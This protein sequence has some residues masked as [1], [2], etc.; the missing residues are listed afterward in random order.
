MTL[1]TQDYGPFADIVK[2]A[3]SIMAMG[4]AIGLGWRGR[5]K[6]EPIEEDVP[7]GPRK[8]GGLIAAITVALIWVGLNDL[9]YLPVLTKIALYCLGVAFLSLM[10]YI[11]LQM[12][13]YEVVRVPAGAL[14]GTDVTEVVKVIGGLWLRSDARKKLGKEDGPN[15]VQDLFAGSAYKKDAL[16][17]RPAQGLAKVFFALAYISLTVAGTV[18]LGAAS[19]LIALKMRAQ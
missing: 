12:L 16:W 8:V 7:A 14:P 10:I 19:I 6:W 3:G 15:T 2:I 18:A 11:L 1:T 4:L 9:Q 13:V 17:P 5:A